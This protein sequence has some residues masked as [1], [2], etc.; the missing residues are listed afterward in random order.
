MRPGRVGLV[1]GLAL[2]PTLAGGVAAAAQDGGVRAFVGGTL[3]DGTGAAPVAEAVVVVQD[4][5][6]ACAGPR[7]R[8]AVPP[9][10]EVVDTRGRWIIP[11]LVDAHVH[12]SQTGWVDGR[13]DAVDLRDRYP[14]AEVE[15]RLRSEPER[16]SRAYLCS[17]VT[18]VFDV[19]GYPWTWDLARRSESDPWA[20]RIAAAGPLL[21]TVDFWLNLP[22]ERQFIF[23]AGEEAV[24]G[25]VQYLAASGAHAVKVWYIMPPQPP[26]TPRVQGLVRVA[27]R[28]AEAREL[29][30]IVHATGLWEA[31]DAVRAGARVLVHSVFQEPVDDE[32]LRLVRE[33][34]VVYTPTIA[35]LEGYADV[36]S[37]EL[38]DSRY[39]LDCV[40]PDT[41][42]FARPD[43]LPADRVSDRARERA[44]SW[45]PGRVRTAMQNAKR[46]HD[47]G[48][49]V[50]VGTD[51]G[52]PGTFHGPS[53]YREMELLQEAGLAPMDVLVAATRTAAQA[54]GRANDLGT[55][56]PG[57]KAD[58]V[59]LEADPTA[60]IRNVRRVSAVVRGGVWHA[61]AALVP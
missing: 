12:Y 18:A 41:R 1:L 10:T 7:S 45:T 27:A 32:F 31:K 3:V 33:A 38:D 51:A 22:A 24:R 55:V 25:G 46:A 54:L 34:G 4:E 50:A 21:S 47:A 52:N 60:D 44:R 30:L 29:P 26:D 53:I 56:E 13:P 16:F 58:L 42:R 28:E 6:I 2:A 20:P 61:R 17:G 11:G 57:K 48:V 39:P 59:I 49:L 43:A 35:V 8:C 9:G 23:M 40:D 14:Y 19:G 5:V 36:Y 37:G 15:A